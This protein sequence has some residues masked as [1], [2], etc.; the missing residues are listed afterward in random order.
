M[1]K[2]KRLQK[3]LSKLSRDY[4]KAEGKP[5]LRARILKS[6]EATQIKLDLI[7]RT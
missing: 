5:L 7:R 4:D 6:A 2:A 1:K 3:K